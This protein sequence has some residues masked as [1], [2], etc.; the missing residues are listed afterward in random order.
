MQG[1]PLHQLLSEYLPVLAT[2]TDTAHPRTPIPIYYFHTA[3]Q[4][5]CDNS[6][7]ECHRQQREVKKLLGLI[8]EG[9]MTLR[10]A[11]DLLIEGKQS[12]GE[13]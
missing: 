12:E 3:E 4:P 2:E 1:I 11:A 6:L 7:C 10:E 5:F 13:I 8:D 9:I